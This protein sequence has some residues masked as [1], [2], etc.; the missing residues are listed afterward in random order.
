M[1]ASV[2]RADVRG[3]RDPLGLTLGAVHGF[4]FKPVN[5]AIGAWV[6]RDGGQARHDRGVVDAGGLEEVRQQ[7]FFG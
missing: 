4:H 3:H 1:C 7:L 6:H 2:E 5:D